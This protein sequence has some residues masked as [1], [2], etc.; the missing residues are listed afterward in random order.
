MVELL[1]K[2]HQRPTERLLKIKFM[3][4]FILTIFISLGLCILPMTSYANSL[5]DVSTKITLAEDS[6]PL[7]FMLGINESMLVTE[8]EVPT[9]GIAIWI[10]LAVFCVLIALFMVYNRIQCNKNARINAR[11]AYIKPKLIIKDG[12]LGTAK[13]S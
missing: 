2:Q 8:T 9:V 13:I 11:N 7:E 3:K 10:G 6:E 12:K 4:K 5:D 1:R